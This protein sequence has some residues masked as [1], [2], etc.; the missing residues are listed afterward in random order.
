LVYLDSTGGHCNPRLVTTAHIVG[1]S[2]YL[3]L[4]YFWGECS[5]TILTK[6]NLTSFHQGIRLDSLPK[7]IQ[8]AITITEQLEFEF[9]C[10]D[11]LCIVQ[12]DP[13]DVYSNCFLTIAALGGSSSN[14][15]LF[16]QR[17]PLVYSKCKMF[18]D[19]N[20]VD[21]Y[22]ELSGYPTG[23]SPLELYFRRAPLHKRGWVTQERLL[24][25]RTLN[26]GVTLIWECRDLF[27]DEFLSS[28]G[29]QPRSTFKPTFSKLQIRDRV[30]D[31]G[32]PLA[33]QEMY[34]FWKFWTKLVEFYT[35]ASLTVKS[36]R[37]VALSGAIASI[38]RNT[39]WR[40]T[41]GLWEPFLLQEL[42]WAPWPLI[43]SDSEPRPAAVPTWSWFSTDGN[44]RFWYQRDAQYLSTAEIVSQDPVSSK[45]D[46]SKRETIHLTCNLMRFSKLPK[47]TFDEND[48][49]DVRLLGDLF[50]M[51]HLS[52]PKLIDSKTATRQRACTKSLFFAPISEENICTR[53]LALRKSLQWPGTY[54]RVGI[55][56]VERLRYDRESNTSKDH[57]SLTMKNLIEKAQ[58][59]T[60]VLI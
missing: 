26:F 12:D 13:D 35:A 9:I 18:Q 57:L 23:P 51:R 6:E 42:L 16:C 30:F 58:R 11:S 41:A 28:R 38:A 4:S 14:T 48:N 7:T 10:V 46:K 54:E 32:K 47:P 3:T 29:G 36:D 15:G 19:R 40:N 20:G 25:P 31:I 50:E 43:S 2:Q 37:T 53:G 5:T 56:I 55:V 59:K 34:S 33:H 24:S 52:H 44:L 39:G 17:D 8:D 21:I 49:A 45:L 22:A 1:S 27:Q 60:I